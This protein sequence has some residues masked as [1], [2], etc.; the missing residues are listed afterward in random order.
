MYHFHAISS[1][2]LLFHKSR[3]QKKT[4]HAITPTTESAFFMRALKKENLLHLET[5]DNSNHFITL[6]LSILIININAILFS[7]SSL[8]SY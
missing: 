3:P 5:Y 4:Y 8:I 1:I 7:L 6:L 2:I